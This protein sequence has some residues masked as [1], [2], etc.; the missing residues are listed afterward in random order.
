MLGTGSERQSMTDNAT[1]SQI[2][3]WADRVMVSL[4]GVAWGI[5][6][7]AT[8]DVWLFPTL[9]GGGWLDYSLSVL[10]LVMGYICGMA[11]RI[12]SPAKK[13]DR[14]IGFSFSFA[15]GCFYTAL[16]AIAL[17]LGTSVQGHANAHSTRCSLHE[18]VNDEQTIGPRR[19][20]VERCRILL[21]SSSW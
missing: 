20:G 11:A 7:L 14:W 12:S 1:S 17:H 21:L 6:A 10:G 18:G 3:R 4:G 5:L 16:A 8:L 2:C 13:A 9:F 15:A 19:Y